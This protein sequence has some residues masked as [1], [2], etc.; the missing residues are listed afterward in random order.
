MNTLTTEELD[1]LE[2][3]CFLSMETTKRLISAARENLRLTSKLRSMCESA[4]D[5]TGM[6]LGEN[7]GSIWAQ[8][9]LDVL[10]GL[11]AIHPPQQT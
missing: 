6:R 9:V 3:H 8:H 7:N 2:E 11:E 10:D 4:L 5:P 1:R